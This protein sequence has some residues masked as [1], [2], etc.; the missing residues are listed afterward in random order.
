MSGFAVDRAEV[1]LLLT[2]KN[3]FVGSLLEDLV[4]LKD[5]LFDLLVLQGKLAC[6]RVRH[7][8]RRQPCRRSVEGRTLFALSVSSRLTVRYH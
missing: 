5:V 7:N 6:S 2:L 3:G 4:L 1:F 8:V